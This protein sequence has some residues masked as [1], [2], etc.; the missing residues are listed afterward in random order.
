[1]ATLTG[2]LLNFVGIDPI[3]ALYWSAVLNGIVSAPLMVVLMLM[4]SNRAVVGKFVLP[5]YL[6]IL[7][8]TATAIMIVVAAGFLL[9][10]LQAIR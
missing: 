1:M 10:R 6:R 9:T 8:W 3:R 2:I 4:S 5:G 7:G